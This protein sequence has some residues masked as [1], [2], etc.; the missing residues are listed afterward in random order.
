MRADEFIT[1]HIVKRGSKWCLLSKKSNKN[2][3]CYPA[4]SGAEK[5]ERQV[6]YFKHLGESEY[7]NADQIWYHGTSRFFDKPSVQGA[8]YLN[9][10]GNLGQGFYITPDPE[11]ASVYSQSRSQSRSKYYG[12]QTG[13]GPHVK[14]YKVKP[15][16]TFDLDQQYTEEQ[17]RE[18]VDKI[19][20]TG[21]P[22]SKFQ[23]GLKQT[24][25]YLF[26]G[27]STGQ[28]IHLLMRYF[29]LDRDTNQL[30]RKMGYQ[31]LLSLGSS[32]P[33]MV[34]LDTDILIPL[35]AEKYENQ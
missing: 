13:I 17:K 19:K 23:H 16:Q 29:A 31:S 27:P 6:Q 34:V 35:L 10:M 7:T 26:R 33:Q 4:K 12:K 21:L 22:E 18:L 5:R 24:A 14:T 15:H 1:E 28:H 20:Q 11:L 8:S 25:K 9:R 3:G 30:F 2:L 32:H